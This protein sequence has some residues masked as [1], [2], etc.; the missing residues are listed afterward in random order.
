MQQ[1]LF[2]KRMSLGLFGCRPQKE[3][4]SCSLNLCMSSSAGAPVWRQNIIH[5]AALSGEG[6]TEEQNLPANLKHTH[7]QRHQHVLL[8]SVQPE[9][10]TWWIELNR[11][12]HWRKSFCFSLFSI[13]ILHF[14]L[15]LFLFFS[16]SL[17]G[18]FQMLR[19][20]ADFNKNMLLLQ[21][22]SDSCSY[23]RLLG[24]KRTLDWCAIFLVAKLGEIFM[25]TSLPWKLIFLACE[26]SNEEPD[27]Q[28]CCLFTCKS[29]EFVFQKALGHFENVKMA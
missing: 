14:S 3:K 1:S 29:S 20:F 16:L 11:M 26:S 6:H 27:Y 9:L 15:C 2:R 28:C 17:G 19:H 23:V 22:Q 7:T 5:R 13:H 24:C 12:I 18:N 10:W 25:S 4:Q 21:L 8:H